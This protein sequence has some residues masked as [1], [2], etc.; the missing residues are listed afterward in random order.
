MCTIRPS[1]ETV[2]VFSRSAENRARFVTRMQPQIRA[3]IIEAADP[4][5]VAKG[6]DLICL[7]TGSNVPV[8]FGEW[9][10]PGQHV[11]SIVASNKGVF[12]QGSVSRPRR[13]F[14]DAVIA[15]ADRVVATLKEQAIMDEQADL[16]EPVARGITSWDAIA[17][18]G[19]LVAGKVPGRQSPGEITVFKQNSDQGVGFMALAKL[20]HDKARAAGLGIEI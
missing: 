4:A 13:E 8:L 2:R 3:R 14:D 1:I 16:F 18:L 20:A 15:R 11:T 19:E 6:A 7:A 17:D 9:L 5:A 10:E 12:L